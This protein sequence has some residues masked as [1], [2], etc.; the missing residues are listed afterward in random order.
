M[1]SLDQ[2]KAHQYLYLNSRPGSLLAMTSFT[3]KKLD[4]QAFRNAE[5]QKATGE[6]SDG[7]KLIQ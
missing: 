7:L 6:F 5:L 4:G 3:L 2:F 1:P